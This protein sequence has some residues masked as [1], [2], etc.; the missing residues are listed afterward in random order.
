MNGDD[1]EIFR[2]LGWV[3]DCALTIPFIKAESIKIIKDKLEKIGVVAS[4]LVFDD[5]S[6]IKTCYHDSAYSSYSSG[7]GDYFQVCYHLLFSSIIKELI[8]LGTLPV[9]PEQVPEDFGVYITIGSFF[10][11]WISS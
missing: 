4:E 2:S 7:A 6:V 3:K 11:D 10:D 1:I 9:I 5:F 8:E